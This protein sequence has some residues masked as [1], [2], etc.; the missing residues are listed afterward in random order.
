MLKKIGGPMENNT[1]L[2]LAEDGQEIAV[3]MQSLINNEFFKTYINS[4]LVKKKHQL[5]VG[6]I[7]AARCLIDY[8][9][10]GEFEIPYSVI[11]NLEFLEEL[12]FVFNQWMVFDSPVKQYLLYNVHKHLEVYI[13]RSIENANLLY[14]LFSDFENFE[15]KVDITKKHR[16]VFAISYKSYEKMRSS[17][18]IITDMIRWYINVHF[19]EI[20]INERD[21]SLPIMKF[22]DDNNIAKLY[23][24][25]GVYNKLFTLANFDCALL[26]AL[27]DEYYNRY[28]GEKMFTSKQLAAI[29]SADIIV[30]GK[31]EPSDNCEKFL[32]IIS[33]VPFV[34]IRYT[35]LGIVDGIDKKKKSFY[36]FLEKDLKKSEKLYVNGK[37]VPI[38]RLV[39]ANEVIEEAFEGE[40]YEITLEELPEDGVNVYKA[41]NI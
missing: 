3:D 28:S 11:E 10:K 33:L 38:Q 13:S 35:Y 20:E 16:L 14:L 23:I 40:T 12:V 37:V 8:I 15:W 22:I 29:N 36:V 17:G 21:I 39:W 4:P 18:R 30:L 1:F 7:E 31:E 34:S 32:S 19:N 5:K 26:P 25:F 6:Y 2:F 41:E 24:K 9:Q 27:I